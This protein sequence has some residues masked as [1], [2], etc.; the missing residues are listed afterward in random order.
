M[1]WWFCRPMKFLIQMED[2]DLVHD[3]LPVDGFWAE[4][5]HR[6]LHMSAM[7]KQIMAV[8]LQEVNPQLHPGDQEVHP[9]VTFQ[10]RR[11]LT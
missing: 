6:A 11:V 4:D 9:T 1:I 7:R 5:C 10:R 2:N 3:R 8:A